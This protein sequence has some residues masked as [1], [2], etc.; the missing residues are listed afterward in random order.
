MK[1]AILM[2]KMTSNRLI[3]LTVIAIVNLF[4]IIMVVVFILRTMQTAHLQLVGFI[5]VIFII[6]LAITV[7]LNIKAKSGRWL[8][9]LPLLFEIFLIV[10]VML[11]YVTKIDFRNTSAIVPYLILYYVSI[12][13]MI[14]YSFL[15]EKRY[16]FI[17]L[18][19]YFFSQFAALY[20]YLMVGHG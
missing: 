20:S 18:V 9:V 13:G 5:W 11:D 15:V 10:E 8:V 4:N 7:F 12:L 17:T 16:G 3:D 19:T 2:K 1:G 6:A 14:G